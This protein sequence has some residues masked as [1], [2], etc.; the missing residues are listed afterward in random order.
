[1]VTNLDVLDELTAGNNNTGT[2]VSSD[3]GE[4]GGQWPVSIN[5]M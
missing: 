1:M 2:F 4:L 3:Q 5:G